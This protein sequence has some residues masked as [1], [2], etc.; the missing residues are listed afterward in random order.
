MRRVFG[1][2]AQPEASTWAGGSLA[3]PPP[4]LAIAGTIVRAKRGLG[5]REELGIGRRDQRKTTYVG[6]RKDVFRALAGA[7]GHLPGGGRRGV[8]DMRQGQ[9]LRDEAGGRRQAKQAN[10]VRMTLVVAVEVPPHVFVPG[11]PIEM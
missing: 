1:Y 2:V 3:S 4:R 11:Y 5:E 6:R 7:G 9:S 8:P 10:N